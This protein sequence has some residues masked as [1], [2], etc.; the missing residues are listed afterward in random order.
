MDETGEDYHTR[1]PRT[2]RK[3][4]TK[5]STKSQGV[6]PAKKP[7]ATKGHTS[8]PAKAATNRGRKPREG[9]DAYD[10]AEVAKDTKIAADNPLFSASGF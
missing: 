6:S 9:V 8:K 1:K 5:T 4:R 2:T 7:R 3:A 10:A